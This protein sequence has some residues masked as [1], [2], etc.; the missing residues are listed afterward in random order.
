MAVHNSLLVV[1]LSL[2]ICQLF[3]RLKLI[4]KGQKLVTRETNVVWTVPAAPGSNWEWYKHSKCGKTRSTAQKVTFYG[5]WQIANV[6]S[7]PQH[8]SVH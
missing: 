8:G 7:T 2:L 4:L 6:F 1:S 3:W 5:G